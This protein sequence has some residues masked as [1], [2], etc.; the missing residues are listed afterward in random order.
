MKGS[1]MS[2]LRLVLLSLVLG[3]PLVA[4]AQSPGPLDQCKDLDTT[5][6]PAIDALALTSSRAFTWTQP[7]DT[8]P[9]GYYKTLDVIFTLTDANASITRLD[10]TCT[11]SRDNNSTDGTPLDCTSVTAGVA[12][13]VPTGV[14]RQ[15]RSAGVGLGSGTYR[16]PIDI[17]NVADLECTASVGAGAAA[18][19]DTISV[20]RRVCVQ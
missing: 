4:S 1:P 11:G 8:A 15:E 3:A 7:N 12:T 18:A 10:W 9:R 16:F 20:W 13:C 19:G 6:A 2:L 14:W 5:A 17:R